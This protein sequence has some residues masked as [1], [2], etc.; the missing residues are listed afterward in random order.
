[1]LITNSMVSKDEQEQRNREKIPK[2][3]M[4]INSIF[5]IPWILYAI[6]HMIQNHILYDL[7]TETKSIVLDLANLIVN[8]VRNPIIA[9]F[10]FKV[11]R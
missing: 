9:H 10:A 1:M 8:S 2:R 11:N 7:S 4:I 6:F 5:L 3:A